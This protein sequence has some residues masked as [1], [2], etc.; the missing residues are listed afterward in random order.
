MIIIAISTIVAITSVAVAVH[1]ARRCHD[2]DKRLMDGHVTWHRWSTRLN[3]TIA[4][5][6]KTQ[7]HLRKALKKLGKEFEQIR[8]HSVVRCAKCGRIYNW[9]QVRDLGN[10]YV[11]ENCEAKQWRER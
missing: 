1:Y 11:C 3:K 5:S 10:Y 7:E 8:A 6:R 9:K 2:L 4:E